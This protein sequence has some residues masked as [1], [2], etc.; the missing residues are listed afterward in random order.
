MPTDYPAYAK[1]LE[2]GQK[3]LADRV[4]RLQETLDAHREEERDNGR[5]ITSLEN[6]VAGMENQVVELG[7]KVGR[8]DDNMRDGFERILRRLPK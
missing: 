2:Q 6:R 4:G 8:L 1:K 7:K 3:K 5:R